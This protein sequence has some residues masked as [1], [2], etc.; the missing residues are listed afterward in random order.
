[1]TH[2][3]PLPTGGDAPLEPVADAPTTPAPP[4]P[5]AFAGFWRR[6]FAYFIDTLALGAVGGILGLLLGDVL[7]GM[8][9]YERL[10]G[11]A[12]ALAF[13]G[14]L[15]SRLTGG[16]TP[17][18]YLL[19]IRVADLQ[20]EPLSVPRAMA[21]QVVF[22][23]PFFLNGAPFSADV[24]LSPLGAVI[25]LLIFGGLFGVIYLYVFNRKTRRSLHDLAVGSC[26]LRAGPSDGAPV[27]P[28][29]WWGHLVVIGVVAV[30]ALVVPFVVQRLVSST[31]FEPLV[32]AQ[33]ALSAEPGVVSAAVNTS[34]QMAGR[35]KAGSYISAAVKID[36][37]KVQDEARARR[38]ARLV[39]DSYP[40]GPE[41]ERIMIVLIHG[42]DMV[43][44]SGS[45]S[46]TYVFKPEDLEPDLP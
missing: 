19:G 40:D 2:E 12:I 13:A 20:G 45:T 7:A 46:Y 17:G 23:L 33:A 37:R 42:Y 21:R 9:G 28:P 27:V 5:P 10:I 29:V 34:V 1:M 6:F 39:L 14:L 41:K 25:S 35:G 43:I 36:S 4:G 30:L 22:S 18:K 26:V 31:L 15:N 3:A 8:G 11:F 32:A 38:M 24:V 16:R 44:A